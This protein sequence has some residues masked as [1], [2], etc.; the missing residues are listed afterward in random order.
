MRLVGDILDV[1]IYECSLHST[2]WQASPSTS[3][4][5][6]SQSRMRML[7]NSL[8]ASQNLARTLISVPF[9]SLNHLIFPIWSG[10]FYSALSVMK[11]VVLRQNGYTASF[12]MQNLPHTVGELLPQG[13]GASTTQRVGKM[14]SLL[15]QTGPRQGDATAEES[16]LV[17]LFQS[18]TQK[19]EAAT[20]DSHEAG[21][22]FVINPFLT[23]V[24]KLQEGL[25]SGTPKSS[26]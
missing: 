26:V 21:S 5:T 10:W 14:T 20:L 17:A 1:M 18:F 19:L 6:M 22:V 16:E 9:T 11:M 24:A 25:L 13:I 15:V 8:K 2:L 4:T 7:Q 3:S 23:K 12:R